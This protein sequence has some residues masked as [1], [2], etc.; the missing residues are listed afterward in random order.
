VGMRSAV[1]NNNSL[2][3]KLRNRQDWENPSPVV[4]CV[5]SLLN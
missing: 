2:N 5:A 4:R 1:N 3:V